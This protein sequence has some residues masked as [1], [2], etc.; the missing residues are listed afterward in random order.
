MCQVIYC[1]TGKRRVREGAHCQECN[2][3][4][5]PLDAGTPPL[6]ASIRTVAHMLHHD[7]ISA[8][9]AALTLFLLTDPRCDEPEPRRHD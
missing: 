9:D 8:R 2:G 5:H 6:I 1:M 7:E 3:F 4:H